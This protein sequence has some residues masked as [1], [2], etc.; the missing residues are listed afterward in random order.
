[1]ETRTLAFGDREQDGRGPGGVGLFQQ[2]G[3]QSSVWVGSAGHVLISDLSRAWAAQHSTETGCEGGVV[4][5][6]ASSCHAPQ[7]CS[8]R[9]LH[10][11]TTA[12]AQAI[13]RHPA[14]YSRRPGS[15][16]D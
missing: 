3:V 9:T 13:I 2:R 8:P 16:P 1:M 12:A 4:V 11:H 14:N 7:L 5:S 15:P 10:M 6:L